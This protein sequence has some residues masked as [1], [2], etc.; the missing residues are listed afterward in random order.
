M[1]RVIWVCLSLGNSLLVVVK[2]NG[3]NNVLFLRC[4]FLERTSLLVDRG[5]RWNP[6]P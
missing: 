1:V 6:L 5:K 3:I 4:V 2:P